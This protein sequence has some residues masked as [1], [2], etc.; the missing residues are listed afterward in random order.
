MLLQVR[1]THGYIISLYNFVSDELKSYF[2]S[3]SIC[4]F[5]SCLSFG[6]VAQLVGHHS[7][8]FFLTMIL[9]VTIHRVTSL[10]NDGVGGS[11]PSV[12]TRSSA[13]LEHQNFPGSYFLSCY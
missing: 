1:K 7:W 9:T 13:G 10:P 2:D 12:A 4:K 5:D 11:N 6:I 3:Y 8:Q